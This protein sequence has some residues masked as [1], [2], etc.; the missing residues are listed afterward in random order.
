MEPVA[1]NVALHAQ[2]PQIHWGGEE[3]ILAAVYPDKNMTDDTISKH[4]TQWLLRPLTRNQRHYYPQCSCF[5][6]V[7]PIIEKP[8]VSVG[9]VNLYHR[10]Q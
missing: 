8:N 2:K 5:G 3:S 7:L 9:L 10:E 4:S 1:H 6:S